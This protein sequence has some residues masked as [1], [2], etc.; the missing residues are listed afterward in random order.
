MAL[1]WH[2]SSGHRFER[3]SRSGCG[4]LAS[5]SRWSLSLALA[6]CATKRTHVSPPEPAVSNAAVP[7]A[8]PQTIVKP[9]E[10]QVI[11]A[12]AELSPTAE[13]NADPIDSDVVDEPDNQILFTLSEAIDFALEQQPATPLCECRDPPRERQGASRL[14][15]VPAASRSL[16]ATRLGLV[17]PCPRRPRHRRL[18]PFQRGPARAPTPKPSS[19]CS[20]CSTTSAAPAAGTCRPFGA[21]RSP[22][23]SS[24]ARGRPS[25]STSRRRIST[26]SWPTPRDALRKT[27]S[28]APRQ[29]CTTRPPAARMATPS[30][31]TS[32]APRCSF[33][34]AART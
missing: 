21:N 12:S 8:M 16:D 28:A 20:G 31:K 13:S 1:P 7:S 9:A 34:K 24:S 33:P 32:S 25:S 22:S 10:P 19:A 5:H 15:T 2:V 14:C 3:G 11:Q 18:H 4:G 26:C 23:S 6:G 17:D 30:A 27:P 29:S